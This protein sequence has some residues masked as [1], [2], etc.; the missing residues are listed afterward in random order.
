MLATAVLKELEKQLMTLGRRVIATKALENSKIIIVNSLTD[1][2]AISNE[3][4]PEHLSLQ[5]DDAEQYLSLIKAA[6]AVFIG[7][8]TPESLGDYVNGPNHVLPTYGYSR[9]YS[10]L[11][12][13]DFMVQINFQ[14]ASQT[15]LQ[16]IA[17]TAECLATL[18]GLT[19]HQQAIRVRLK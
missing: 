13:N 6:G 3:Y 18:E 17:K 2:I 4:A 1:A 15:A 8:W 12:T 19:G 10:G 11:S 7:H 14:K 16:Q 9:N 5:I